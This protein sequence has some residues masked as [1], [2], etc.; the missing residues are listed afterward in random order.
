MHLLDRVQSMKKEKNAF[1]NTPQIQMI[2]LNESNVIASI[3][4]NDIM[5]R[6]AKLKF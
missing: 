2:Y 3:K 4:Q 6:V 5:S 1:F